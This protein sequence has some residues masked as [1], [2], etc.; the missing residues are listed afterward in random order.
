MMSVF[1]SLGLF[2][3]NVAAFGGNVIELEPIVITPSR[4]DRPVSDVS[5][6]VTVITE[7]NI[8]DSGAGSVPELIRTYS[9]I[10]VADFSGNPK[11]MVVDIRGFGESGL[12]NVLVLV[13]GRRTNQAD[14]S[15]VDWAQISVGSIERIE[16][17]RGPA[18]VLYG[19]NAAAGVINIITK[20]GTGIEPRM[21]VETVYGS[22]QSKKG[23][24]SVEGGS[25][26]LDYYFNYAYQDTSGYRANNDYLANDYFGNITIRPYK[27]GEIAF[28]AGYHTDRYG[29][30]GALYLADI[31]SIGRRGT[32]H[33]DDRGFTWDHF[34]TVQPCMEFSSGDSDMEIS[35]FGSMRDRR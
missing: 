33:T 32:T 27:S 19:D 2:F 20:K 23:S 15:G 30:P 14:L 16:I 3:G 18:T 10:A 13:D 25:E 5:R 7:E 4:S 6:G 17:V 29:M 22:Y 11:G 21:S 28:S 9:G 1:L 24:V 12:S 35:V 26:F 31:E 8:R 34:A